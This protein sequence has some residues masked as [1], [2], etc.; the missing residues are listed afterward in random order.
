[1]IR[2][3][4]VAGLLASAL[5][6]GV[7]IVPA[8]AAPETVQAPTV[9]LVLEGLTDAEAALAAPSG[10]WGWTNCIR[11]VVVF[12]G[13]NALAG[14]KVASLV[15]KAGSITRAIQKLQARIARL[16]KA[17]KRGAIIAGIIGVGGELAGV[18]EIVT[19]C[20]DA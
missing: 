10:W 20:F 12:A 13:T 19:N 17:Q 8:Q 15:K 4:I 18:N 7:G 5:V 3:C 11:A 9:V 6:G 16:P 2:R 1:M 14:L